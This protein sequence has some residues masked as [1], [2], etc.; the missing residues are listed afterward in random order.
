MRVA[1]LW[2]K[3]RRARIETAAND[4]AAHPDGSDGL[5]FLESEDF[6]VRVEDPNG[7]LLNPLARTHEVFSGLDPLR[8]LRVA[9]RRPPYDAILSIGASSAWFTQRF[10][11][12]RRPRVPVIVIDPAMGP[13]RLRKRMQER[14]IPRAD[15]VI[16][17]G[18]VQLDELRETYGDQTRGVFVHHR[19]DVR[20]Y[21]PA[22]QAAA[23]APLPYV[24]A[25]GDDVSRDFATLVRACAP[26]SALGR[27]LAARGMRCVIHTGRD[28]GPLPARVEPS[29]RRLSHVALRDLYRHATAVILPLHDVRHAGGINSLVEAMAMARP[30]AISASRGILDYVQDAVT[31]LT[32]PPGDADALGAA[33]CR[34]IED[35]AL[36]SRLGAAARAFVVSTC[37]SPVYAKKIAA[38]ILEARA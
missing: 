26:E 18:R 17:F 34:L 4:P 36:A 20:F 33:A 8:A 37:A 13:W 9:R 15:R 24:L 38:I 2:P 19:A 3:P 27:L 32:V 21:D 1:L 23:P 5:L 6:T 12:R 25:I 10:V 35:S 14:I 28:L 16:V 31:A 11:A 22:T 7:L 29:S 30:I